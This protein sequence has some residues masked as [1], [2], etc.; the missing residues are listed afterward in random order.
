ML[1]RHN[2]PIFHA[3]EIVERDHISDSRFKGWTFQQEVAIFTDATA[4]ILDK[5]C[6]GWPCAV[7]L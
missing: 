2:A 3:A 6:H 4:L 1:V 5:R 7:W